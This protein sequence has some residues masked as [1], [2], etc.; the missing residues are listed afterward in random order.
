[1]FLVHMKHFQI[2]PEECA[3]VRHLEMLVL[4]EVAADQVVA[5][6]LARGAFAGRAAM[7]EEDRTRIDGW[8]C[9]AARPY[10]PKITS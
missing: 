7:K 2:N 9:M 3:L 6:G 8:R 1:M 10:L 5:T 4:A